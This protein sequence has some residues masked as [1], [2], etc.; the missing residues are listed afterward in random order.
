MEDNITVN[1]GNNSLLL[2][3]HNIGAFLS[4]RNQIRELIE[5]KKP[6]IF[7]A[8]EISRSPH[9]LKNIEGYNVWFSERTNQKGG[10]IATWVCDKE[11]CNMV[12]E[13]SIFIQGN[14]ESI[15]VKLE[16]K[17]RLLVNF[18][19]PPSGR[20]EVFFESLDK[21]LEYASKNQFKVIMA[22]D[23]NLN[24]LKKSPAKT[25]LEGILAKYSCSQLITKFTRPRS[26][27]LLD[28]ILVGG[29]KRCFSVKTDYT[30]GL[31]DH[32]SN[33]LWEMRLR[34]AMSINIEEKTVNVLSFS[35]NAM[36]ACKKDLDKVDWYKWEE[37][38]LD[39]NV[40]L[41]SLI[42]HMCDTIKNN[43]YKVIRCRGKSRSNPWFTKELH[44]L[45]MRCASLHNKQAR[46]FCPDRARVLRDLK[47]LYRKTIRTNKENYYEGKFVASEHDPKRTWQL[48]NE[49]CGKT[50]QKPIA[51]VAQN[52]MSY[53]GKQMADR[54]N[55]YFRDIPA[56]QREKLPT[57]TKH[58]KNYME[59]VPTVAN[60]LNIVKLDRDE[61]FK[62]L[63][64]L[65]P[66]RGPD[67]YGIPPII[68][69][70]LRLQLVH[71]L[72]VLF[73]K[74]LQTSTWPQGLKL[75]RVVPIPKT[76]EAANIEN[77]RPISLVTSISKVFERL[78]HNKI[79][80]HLLF[81]NVLTK[82]Q[83]GFRHGHSTSQAISKMVS[84]ICTGRAAGKK[85]AV[86]L[87]DISKA[88][89]TIDSTILLGKLEHYGIGN[90][91][92]DL[93]ASYLTDRKQFVDVGGS[94][95]D[96]VMLTG[97]GVPQ[98]SILGPLLFLIYLNDLNFGATGQ[99]LVI[100]TFADDTA[101]VIADKSETVLY[102]RLSVC[103]NKMVE[104]FTSNKLSVNESKTKLLIFGNPK[105]AAQ[106]TMNNTRLLP[107]TKAKYL[108]VTI[109]NKLKFHDHVI[110]VL[111]K[112]RTGNFLLKCCRQY[113]SKR[114]R[115]CVFNA[116]VNCHADY[117]NSIWGNMANSVDLKKIT[118][119]QKQ[120]IRHVSRVPRLAH[121]GSLFKTHKVPKFLDMVH[122]SSLKIC[123]KFLGGLLPESIM[124][125]LACQQ[126]RTLRQ[127]PQ[128]SAKKGDKLFHNVVSHFNKMSKELRIRA[129]TSAQKCGVSNTVEESL[130]RGYKDC[131]GNGCRLCPGRT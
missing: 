64:S 113:L 19:R 114:A 73:N 85:V 121:T 37:D 97:H 33:E 20:F 25:R 125:L 44:K 51:S 120:G 16:K 22:G 71:P 68:L 53:S 129:A 59:N 50:K 86:S 38:H 54:F 108:G 130:M 58:Y 5:S 83:Y 106:V 116:L 109:D 90:T 99:G 49:I 126:V 34:E 41:T 119:A 63:R 91:T 81:N 65:K 11:E 57:T 21:Q 2:L 123:E 55:E 94:K 127:N 104:W 131:N 128:M 72:T 60:K 6:K 93:I 27:T 31:S 67:S 110:S 48:I 61:V 39:P 30:T 40:M 76:K 69:K 52:G 62:A 117:C 42:K 36:E 13:I 74:C 12:P 87:L 70:E 18:Y 92:R 89:D 98:G 79:E 23:A 84:E 100:I 95:S 47:S 26:R 96:S 45:K 118:T 35:D 3:S 103:L 88:F 7:M 29:T 107:T 66:K 28:F 46:N 78:I 9:S 10:G 111:A 15:A 43:C 56:K 80:H 77:F 124:E 122:L 32:A 24:W 102:K 112:M 14:Y 82:N 4:N 101:L 1:M 8:Q 75:S 105:N 115:L 17:K